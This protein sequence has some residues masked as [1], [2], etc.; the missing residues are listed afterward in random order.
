MHGDTLTQC[1]GWPLIW[2]TFFPHKRVLYKS[3]LLFLSYQILCCFFHASTLFVCRNKQ[4]RT[5]WCMLPGCRMGRPVIGQPNTQPPSPWVQDDSVLLCGIVQA[6]ACVA[7]KLR[8]SSLCPLVW[9]GLHECEALRAACQLC[10]ERLSQRRGCCFHAEKRDMPE[11]EL[12]CWATAGRQAGPS[13]TSV[14]ART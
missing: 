7:H 5:T 6:H 14:Y 1:S 11:A 8:V 4:S 12:T 9:A 3:T 13:M 10:G 2:G